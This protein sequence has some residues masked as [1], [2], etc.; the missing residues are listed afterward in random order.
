[1]TEFYNFLISQ[2]DDRFAGIMVVLVILFITS[3]ITITQ[4][5]N[6]LIKIQLPKWSIKFPTRTPKHT[7]VGEPIPND[8]IFN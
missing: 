7:V 3:A 4:V 5:I 6:T 8:D 2:T 1:M